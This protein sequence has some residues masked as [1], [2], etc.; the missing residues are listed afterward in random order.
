MWRL[1][2]LSLSLI[3]SLFLSLSLSLSGRRHLRYTFNR[4]LGASRVDISV[5]QIPNS[6]F[7]HIRLLKL[8]Y[9]PNVTE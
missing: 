5:F 1:K 7:G 3:P 4:K 9:L 6:Q 2:L 8:T